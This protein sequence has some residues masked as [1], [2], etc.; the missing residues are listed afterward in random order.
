MHPIHY[1]VLFHNLRG[2]YTALYCQLANE[3]NR[4]FTKKLFTFS[5][6]LLR[7]GQSLFHFPKNI[8]DK[9]LLVSFLVLDAIFNHLFSALLPLFAVF[10]FL[11]I[12]YVKVDKQ[13]I[14]LYESKYS[15]SRLNVFDSS[16]TSIQHTYVPAHC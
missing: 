16:L 6:D 10:Y 11:P 9:L 2:D 15:D 14:N 3:K 13:P 8:N 4:F 1:T 5:S 7:K 12:I